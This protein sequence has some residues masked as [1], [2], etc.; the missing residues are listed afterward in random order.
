MLFMGQI[1]IHGQWAHMS[2]FSGLLLVAFLVGRVSATPGPK[3]MPSPTPGP[4]WPAATTSEP[5]TFSRRSIRT[6]PTADA[7]LYLGISYA[8]TREWMT[9]GRHPEGRRLPLSAGSSIPQRARGRLSGRKRS[10]QG[11]P[12]PARSAR[13]SIRP[14]S[15]RR[16]FWRT[17]DMSMGNIESALKTL[18]QGRHDPL[19]ATFCTTATSR[20]ENWTIG[21]ASAFQNGRD[22]DLG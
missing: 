17:V 22:A 4:P 10:H 9:R 19:S 14:T 11:A 6:E 20:F 3:M 5:L 16:T 13:E 8:H 18:E 1:I 15:T 12:I 7:Y 21:K 2:R